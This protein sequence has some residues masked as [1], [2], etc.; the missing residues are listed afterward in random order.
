[1][2]YKLLIS[3]VIKEKILKGVLSLTVENS[4]I[5]SYGII[6]KLKIKQRVEYAKYV[7]EDL[8][9][10][11]FSKKFLSSIKISVFSNMLK[12]FLVNSS[13]KKSSTKIFFLSLRFLTKYIRDTFH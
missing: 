5:T 7:L 4:L 1:M 11:S 13:L 9:K 2:V 10:E 8:L 3:S 6:L 12:F